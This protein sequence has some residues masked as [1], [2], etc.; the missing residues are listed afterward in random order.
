MSF[1]RRI[2]ALLGEAGYVLQETSCLIG[3][4]IAGRLEAA[5]DALAERRHRAKSS[6]SYPAS[7]HLP[8]QQ[9]VDLT[10]YRI[11]NGHRHTD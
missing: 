2:R 1:F 3:E 6:P 11:I 5:S 9:I 4:K 10:E 7:I 8:S